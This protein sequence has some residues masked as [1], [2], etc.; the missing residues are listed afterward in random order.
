[1]AGQLD[2]VVNGVADNDHDLLAAQVGDRLVAGVDCVHL[3]AEDGREALP[4]DDGHHVLLP[5]DDE[6]AA[7][8]CVVPQAAGLLAASVDC[9]AG[10]G[11]HPLP[12]AEDA[13]LHVALVDLLAAVHKVDGAAVLPVADGESTDLTGSKICGFHTQLTPLHQRLH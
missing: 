10:D 1:M 2:S 8:L 4:V 5:D 6:D 11:H 3:A 12:A 13:V 9:V 7:H